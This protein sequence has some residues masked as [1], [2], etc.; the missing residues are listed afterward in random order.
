[1][2]RQFLERGDIKP[3]PS[4]NMLE[5]WRER[6]FST[7]FFTSLIAA[8]VPY[9]LNMKIAIDSGLI[10]TGITYPSQSESLCPNPV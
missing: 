4:E 5:M 8:F 1:M 7:I 6:V 3:E 10:T 2:F 9:L